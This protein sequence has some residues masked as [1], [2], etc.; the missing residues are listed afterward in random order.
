MPQYTDFNGTVHYINSN[1]TFLKILSAMTRYSR[2]SMRSLKL[3]TDQGYS[4][5]RKC[6]HHYVVVVK[7]VAS[8]G[9]FSF[10]VATC[11][12]LQRY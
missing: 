2:N 5:R 11:R 3:A 6:K 10:R 7:L 4:V 8:L 9:C 1:C 12:L